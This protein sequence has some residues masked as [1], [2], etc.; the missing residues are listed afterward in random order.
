MKLFQYEQTFMNVIFLRCA[1]SYFKHTKK[2][3]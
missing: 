1:D 3:I 2:E